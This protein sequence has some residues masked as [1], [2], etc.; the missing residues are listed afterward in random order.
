MKYSETGFRALYHNFCVIKLN[1]KVRSIIT[2]CPG[3]EEADSVLT[4]GYIDHE[5]GFTLEILACAKEMEENSFAYADKVPEDIT[6]KIR[7]G[8]V[9]EQEFFV[10]AYGDDEDYR[11]AYK[12]KVESADS[13]KVSEEVENTRMFDFLDDFRSDEYPDDVRVLLIRS[14]LQPEECWARIEGLGDKCIIGTLL[15]E[16]YQ[17]F[18]YHC[19]ER[20]AFFVYHDDED[21]TRLV[22]DMNPSV[23]VTPED[24]EDGSMLC[25]AITSFNEEKNQD[26]FLDVLEILRDSYVWIPCNAIVGEDDINSI[27]E[28]IANAGDDLDSLVGKTFSNQGNI[29]LV[30]DILKNGDAQF[31]PVF[32][33]VESMGDY[34]NGVSKLQKHF[35]EAIAMAKANDEEF[36]GIVINAFSE[37]MVIDAEVFDIIENMKSRI[38][39]GE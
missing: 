28:M 3:A 21:N 33:N 25:K 22:S 23:K 12:K 20:V 38:D 13:Y 1:D 7:F 14:G 31:F 18:G 24:L 34:G 8:S 15:N 16:P 17:D 10:M 5:A 4:Y 11:N 39:T 6:L 27:E 30:P 36:A 29:R 37:P 26:H 9:I 35:L 2:D 32:A 19:G